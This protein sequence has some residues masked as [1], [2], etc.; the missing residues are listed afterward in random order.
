MELP[1]LLQV[2]IF[3]FHVYLESWVTQACKSS[4]EKIKLIKTRT[5]MQN[6]MS[7]EKKCREIHVKFC[8]TFYGCNIFFVR[9]FLRLRYVKSTKQK[10]IKANRNEALLCIQ[11][12]VNKFMQCLRCYHLLPQIWFQETSS[13]TLNV[14]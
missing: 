12:N 2:S 1:G 8:R 13:R 6:K 3:N 4:A 11:W 10:N 14:K 9:H 7:R 5:E